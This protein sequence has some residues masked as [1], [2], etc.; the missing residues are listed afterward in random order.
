[1]KSFQARLDVLP[2]AQRSLWPR[3]AAVQSDFVLYGGTALA[4]RLG[5]RQ[6]V[7][8]DFFT[9][10]ELEPEAILAA[11]PF[12]EAATVLQSE[13]NTYTFQVLEADDF[14]R[15]S[16]FGTI[17][18]GRIRGPEWTQDG[19]LR[20]ASAE[21]ILATKLKVVMQRIETK[22][23]QD[24]AALIKAGYSLAGGLGGTQALFGN[25][26]SPV[27]CLRALEYFEDPLLEDLG[28]AERTV[29]KD[30]VQEIIARGIPIQKAGKIAA[31]F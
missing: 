19:V 18:F 15:I 26:F 14:V 21:D 5:H 4:L 2:P 24:I 12:L 10:R 31:L 7:D 17:S 11:L 28:R 27:D 25:T 22:D 29:L 20:V 6:S 3:F 30:A 8:F 23:Y 9:H 13:K 1:M 16:F